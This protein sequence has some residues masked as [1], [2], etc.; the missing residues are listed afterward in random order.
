MTTHID[1]D[2]GERPRRLPGHSDWGRWTSQIAALFGVAGLAV[3]QPVLDTFG[4]QP[5]FFVAGRYS[6]WQVVAFALVV[7]LVPA[8]LAAAAVAVARRVHVRA[9]AAFFVAALGLF[10]A[11]LGLSIARSAGLGGLLPCVLVA[12]AC[13]GIVVLVDR[14]FRPVRQFLVLLAVG[15]LVFL[16]LFLVASPTAE[17][18][19]GS[20]TSPG[21]GT[22]DVPPLEGP[23]VV[24]VLD[25]FPLTSL[26][27]PDGSIDE[28]RFPGF[29]SLAEGSSWFRNASSEA[30]ETHLAVPTIVTGRRSAADELPTFVD[31]PRNLLSLFEDRYPLRVY[32]TLTDLCPPSSCGELPDGRLAR[33]LADAA[34]VYGHKVLPTTFRDRLPE[35][36]Q[37]WGGFTGTEDAGDVPLSDERTLDQYVN[38]I[39]DRRVATDAGPV[40]G[41]RAIAGS[42]TA[43]PSINLAHLL[44]PHN[45][46]S[47]SPSGVPLAGEVFPRSAPGDPG[48]PGYEFRHRQLYQAHAWQVGATDALI[49]ELVAQLQLTGA[50]EDALVVVVGD[51]GIDLTSPVA[52]R[53]LTEQSQDEVLRVPLFIKAP[54]QVEGEVRDDPASTVDVLPSIL[55]LL[56]AEVSDTAAADI[57]GHSLFDGSDP[58]FD[59]LLS[60]ELDSALAVVARRAADVPHGQGWTGVAAVG[61]D[62]DLVGRSVDEFR[63]GEPSS[64]SW[65]LDQQGA[66][67]D[68]STATGPLPLLLGG[69]VR[70]SDEPPPELL[71]ALNG[72]LAGPIGGYAPEG[73]GWRFTGLMDDHLVDGANQVAAYE[74]ERTGDQVVLHPVEG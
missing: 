34:V 35:V 43:E 45:P 30:T 13:A 64:L 53:T 73:D 41:L 23:V 29:A 36:D 62:G 66:L 27:T 11:G 44:L 55:D 21:W 42:I 26:I 65:S 6:R 8:A 71:V 49:G 50:W 61:A 5:M 1:E 70:G 47:R 68:V 67:A 38:E 4:R 9:G 24:V 52:G 56:D 20:S 39:L 2:A 69:L 46:W 17:V 72:T 31:H 51:H 15:N 10:A 54:G 37:T 22:V 28:T 14:S 33:A 19:A 18:V 25:E 58:T 63:T 57:E 40:N 7:A 60:T 74:V 32:E 12:A 59:R 3:T 48:A 16:G